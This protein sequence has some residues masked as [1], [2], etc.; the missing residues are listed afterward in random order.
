MR[1]SIVEH[2]S[3]VDKNEKVQEEA[4]TIGYETINNAA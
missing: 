4:E 1:R 2:K 3:T